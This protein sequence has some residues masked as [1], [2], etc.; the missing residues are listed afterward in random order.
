MKTCQTNHKNRGLNRGVKFTL[1]AG[2][3]L[4]SF[5]AA[6]AHAQSAFGVN[7]VGQLFNFDVNAPG[8][9][10]LVGNIGFAPDGI[11]FNPANGQLL[12]LQVG[13]TTSSLFS[14]NL[15]N[16]T[17]TLIGSFASSGAGYNLTRASSFGFDVNPKTLQVD[18]SLRVRIVD[19][20]GDN[21][22]L[23]TSTG[24]VAAVQTPLTFAAGSGTG[25]PAVVGAAYTNNV[26]AASGITTLFDVTS[27]SDG[28]YRQDPPASGSLSL[29]GPFA[30]DVQQL[31]GFDIFT[32]ANG[33]NTAY[34]STDAT[35]A[36]FGAE[37]YAVDLTSGSTILLGGIGNGLSIT[38]IAVQAVPEPSTYAMILGATIFGAGWLHR[39][40]RRGAVAV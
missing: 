11:D 37:L 20:N 36:V 1:L 6:S 35:N 34:L 8:A 12:A 14:L 24:A 2:S 9:A 22:I 28:L 30:I 26:A 5:A 18:G 32:A 33:F 29:V 40:R 13:T 17:P 38:D 16:A 10:A 31:T 3:L 27:L 7:A 25:L 19:N 21:L 23:N 15:S 4:S 39:G